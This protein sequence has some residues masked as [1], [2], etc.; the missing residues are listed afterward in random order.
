MTDKAFRDEPVRPT[1]RTDYDCSRPGTACFY[2]KHERCVNCG[3][4]KGWKRTGAGQR[5]IEA[6]CRC[7]VKTQAE[8]IKACVMEGFG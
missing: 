3:R 1:P 8:C 2:N 7:N 4:R 5:R 6:R